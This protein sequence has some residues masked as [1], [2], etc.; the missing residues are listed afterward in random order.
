MALTDRTQGLLERDDELELAR[1][2]STAAAA[3]DGALLL[4]EGPAGMGKSTLLASV[5]AVAEEEGLRPLL[6]IGSELD[7]AFPFGVARD[8]LGP[9]VRD[10]GGGLL[11]G[12]AGLA[13]P[14]FGGTSDAARDIDAV[15]HGLYW[16]CA[17]LAED[18]PLLLAIDDAHWADTPSLRALT[19]LGRR[20]EGLPLLLVCAAR[21]DG[22]A[23]QRELLDRL[24]TTP[25]QRTLSLEPLSPEA[26]GAVVRQRM[27]DATTDAFS[28]ACHRATGGNPFYLR[29]LLTALLHDDVA[30]TAAAAEAVAAVGP[31]S[32]GRSVAVRLEA[33]S[34]DHVAIA[35][36][37]AVLG[38]GTPLV[39]AAALAGV[40]HDRAGECADDL[41]VAQILRPDRPLRFVHAIVRNAVLTALSPGRMSRAHRRAA[42]LLA[43]EHR[44]PLEL[45]GHLLATEPA[46][47]E[48][49][50]EQL[51]AA[52]AEA[53]T[54]GAT[55]A[56]ADYLQRALAEPPGDAATAR[57]LELALARVEARIPRAT[58]IERFQRVLA[59][60]NDPVAAAGI[61]RELAP[62]LALA[63]RPHEGLQVA[64]DGL[65]RL[66]DREPVLAHR[67]RFTAIDVCE[68]SKDL[69]PEVPKR[70]SELA[71][72]D[73]SAEPQLHYALIVQQARELIYAGQERDR[74]LAMLRQAAAIDPRPFDREI[75]ESAPCMAILMFWMCDVPETSLTLG[76][77]LAQ[78][79]RARG[80]LQM[81]ALALQYR[82]LA[83]WKAGDLPL[84]ESEAQLGAALLGGWEFIYVNAVHPLV[85]AAVE[86]GQLDRAGELLD[87]IGL[88]DGVEAAVDP[89]TRLAFEARGRY[90][91]ARN[92]P[93]KALAD[94]QAVGAHRVADGTQNPV[95]SPWRSQ[96]ALALYQLSRADEAIVLA[97][98]ELELARQFG[99][100]RG[101][102]V[103]LRARAL[104][105]GDIAEAV[106]MLEQAVTALAGSSA[107]LEYARALVDL[108]A[109]M[110]RAG[111]RES[112][113]EPLRKGLDLS[114]RCG[115]DALAARAREELV[116]GGSRPRR[117]ALS[118]VASLTPSE[119][120]VCELAVEGMTNRQIAQTLFLTVK[121]IED[122]L[123]NAYRKLDVPSRKELPAAMAG[124]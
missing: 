98:E 90:R 83:A 103:A 70:L 38:D 52:A 3:G 76:A 53:H 68:M 80:D 99:A 50:V 105:G 117:T 2:L 75:Y 49:V 108:G 35:Q 95:V 81:L 45:A 86:R 66:G 110:R 87:S 106:A 122:H 8:L 46:A 1:S 21:P 119:R 82:A 12:A 109:A 18:G 44:P 112:S 19:Y 17:N 48:F 7:A 101:I 47:D 64:V 124:G 89:P 42:G 121:T 22:P 58:A 56:E 5:L 36:A 54:R 4:V 6:G 14:L 79:S 123:R 73:L 71:T 51:T 34:A 23:G 69:R 11:A 113:R 92:E 77:D 26:S 15:V 13:A 43:D 20:L 31:R 111:K 59:T 28:V 94:F 84:A 97:D 24:A 16:V 40:A 65:R 102:G 29:E 37:A 57:T 116:A 120:R 39:R 115:A 96:A 85:E 114:A 104:V 25:G 61:C 72:F 41:A 55:E 100:P 60:E 30:P 93:A 107:R 118:G 78:H 67:L 63:G 74:A 62:T 33:L 10:A 9:A 91:L 88:G 32:V 27:G